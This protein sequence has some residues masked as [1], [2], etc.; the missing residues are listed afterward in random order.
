M[1]GF[2]SIVFSC[3]TGYPC[4]SNFFSGISA[5]EF[6]FEYPISGGFFWWFE[7]QQR[8]SSFYVFVL[9]TKNHSSCG[10]IEEIISE[11]AFMKAPSPFQSAFPLSRLELSLTTT[12]DISQFSSSR[13][14]LWGTCRFFRHFHDQKCGSKSVGDAPFP[15]RLNS[16]SVFFFPL[17]VLHCPEHPL[18][19][20]WFSFFRNVQK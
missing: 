18:D 10:S 9:Q 6:C 2:R 19:I 17:S 1:I 12:E 13:L 20:Y 7:S 8:R 16:Q 11:R 3:K 4:Q 15:G 14:A 5:P